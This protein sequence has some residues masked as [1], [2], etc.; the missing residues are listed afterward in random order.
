MDATTGLP[1]ALARTTSRQ[2]VSEPVTEPP[3]A[4]HPQDDRRYVVIGDGSR[5]AAAMVSPPP[6]LELPIGSTCGPPR[7]LTIGP[8]SV[9]TAMVGLLFRP[10]GMFGIGLAAV[11]RAYRDRNSRGGASSPS[12]TAAPPLSSAIRA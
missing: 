6:A 2:M 5:R 10:G 1:A 12:A 9:T 11:A 7:P 3:G 8:C 4:V